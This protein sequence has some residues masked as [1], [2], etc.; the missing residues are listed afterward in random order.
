MIPFMMLRLLSVIA[1]WGRAGRSGGRVRRGAGKFAGAGKFGP[2]GGGR[3]GG[4]RGIKR[5][6][7]KR[8]VAEEEVR[9]PRRH[10]TPRRGGGGR[11]SP[12]HQPL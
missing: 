10:G 11:H 8:V 3:G 6:P 4:G 5:A 12:S 1:N 9:T 7:S 2:K